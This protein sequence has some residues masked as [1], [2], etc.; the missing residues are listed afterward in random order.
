MLSAICFNLDQSKVLSSVNGLIHIIVK[1]VREDNYSR[2]IVYDNENT[3]GKKEML[4]RPGCF[5]L[6]RLMF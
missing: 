5:F 3:E 4:V 1:Y 2:H 6:K